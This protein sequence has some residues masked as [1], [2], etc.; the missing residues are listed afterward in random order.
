MSISEDVKV[1]RKRLGIKKLRKIIPISEF[2]KAVILG[3][4]DEERHRPVQK[5]K[6]YA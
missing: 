3:L 2:E 5:S 1:L 6:Q 4:R